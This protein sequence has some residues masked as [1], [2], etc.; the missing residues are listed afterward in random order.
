MVFHNQLTSTEKNE[1]TRM[2]EMPQSKES[3]LLCQTCQELHSL[4]K[5]LA[6]FGDNKV[7]KLQ[8]RAG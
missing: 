6:L 3:K 1:Q 8:E 4:R 7:R 5:R 2:P